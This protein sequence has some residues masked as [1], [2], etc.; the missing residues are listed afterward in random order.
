MRTASHPPNQKNV[1]GCSTCFFQEVF[2]LQKKLSCCTWEIKQKTSGVWHL[3]RTKGQFQ[4]C[5]PNRHW[6]LSDPV[7][8]LQ[9]LL[10]EVRSRVVLRRP[11]HDGRWSETSDLFINTQRMNGFWWTSYQLKTLGGKSFNTISV[12]KKWPNIGQPSMV[13]AKSTEGSLL[14]L[15]IP[16]VAQADMSSWSFKDDLGELQYPKKY[17]ECILQRKRSKSN[18]S[19]DSFDPDWKYLKTD[20]VAWCFCPLLFSSK[21]KDI[22]RGKFPTRFVHWKPRLRQSQIFSRF[23]GLDPLHRI[24]RIHHDSLWWS[25]SWW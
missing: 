22:W 1:W 13:S 3:I 5:R 20:W 21:W 2:T 12:F 8:A 18:Y 16:P 19:N 7:D 4:W 9:I 10:R 11:Q 17:H 23:Q 6:C 14:T 25:L 24:P 15:G